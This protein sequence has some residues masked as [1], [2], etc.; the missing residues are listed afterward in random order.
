M[1]ICQLTCLL[2]ICYNCIA[3]KT[4]AY[5]DFY[6]KPCEPEAASFFSTVEKTDSGW[7]RHDY[8]IQAKRLQMKAL[9]KD[10][11]CDIPNGNCKYYYANG[12]P[13]SI[14]KMIGRKQE[15]I[16]VSYH[17]NGV[18]SDSAMFHD[19][20]VADK[21]FR[22]HSNG[23]MSDSIAKVNDSMYVQVGWFDDGSVAYAGYLLYGKQTGKWKY[24]HHN[25]QLSSTE[26]YKDGK[27]IETIYFDEKG[28]T[29]TGSSNVEREAQFKGGETGWRKYLERKIHWPAGLQFTTSGYVTVGISF[30]VDENGKVTDA[31]VSLPFHDSFDKIALEIIKSSP[32]W[33]PAIS[34][35]RTVKA[36]RK[37]PV[38]FVQPD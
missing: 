37:Q 2:L 22:W 38:T 36:W 18:I 6:W 8:Y 13:S 14:G 30:A 9:Y 3:Q 32:P 35:N 20:H 29:L 28:T 5:Y 34:H 10:E 23:Y 25:G 15:G 12:I 7:L 11:A 19:G 17:Y 4:E 1:K 31:Y 21:R 16:C 24:Y 26:V 33:Q 27:A